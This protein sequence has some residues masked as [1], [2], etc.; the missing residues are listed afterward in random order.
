MSV[1]EGEGLRHSRVHRTEPPNLAN[2]NIVSDEDIVSSARQAVNHD[3]QRSP[4]VSRVCERS[5]ARGVS[6]RATARADDRHARFHLA[7]LGSYRKRSNFFQAWPPTCVE[8]F[9][10]VGFA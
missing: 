10:R 7:L 5:L 4:T 6:V 8:A 3:D 2:E 1:H 9:H